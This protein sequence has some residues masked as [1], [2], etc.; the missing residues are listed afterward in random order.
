M[1]EI[2]AIVFD[3]LRE[4][5]RIY[6]FLTQLNFGQCQLAPL[7]IP[8]ITHSIKFL[9]QLSIVKCSMERSTALS[10]FSCK[11]PFLDT[12]CIN[13]TRIGISGFAALCKADWPNLAKILCRDIGIT[14][15]ALKYLTKRD[16]SKAELIHFSEPNFRP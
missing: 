2:R 3:L 1:V 6:R 8:V 4:V 10:L 7:C 15:D 11:F 12:L 5:T 14:G 9:K 16:N 13:F